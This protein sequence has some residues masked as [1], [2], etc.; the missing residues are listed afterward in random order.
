MDP[1]IALGFIASVTESISLHT[2]LL[3]PA[4]RNALLVAKAVESLCLLAPGRLILGVG[5]GYLREEF[6]A[7]GVPYDDRNTL[8]DDAIRTVRRI[9][10][11][12]VSE[13]PS[14]LEKLQVPAIWI[15]GNSKAAIRRSVEI[16]DGW[17][18]IA[19]NS[20]ASTILKTPGISTTEDLNQRI[21]FLRSYS[22]QRGRDTPVTICFTPRWAM[23]PVVKLPEISYMVSNLGELS[24]L[25]VSW[26][27]ICL[28]GASLGE[29]EENLE[30]FGTSVIKVAS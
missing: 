22:A 1:L 23:M 8:L 30:Q 7:L 10:D 19:S 11:E 28:P 24:D 17:S 2:N 5:S 20:K 12:R 9:C 3:V 16:G 4:Y 13:G 14:S 15:G 26:V 21:Q 29:L 25:G 27:T 6:D 18:P